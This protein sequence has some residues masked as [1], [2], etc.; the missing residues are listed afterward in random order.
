ME[1]ILFVSAQPDVPYFIWQI[2]L[3]I[4]NFIEKG[5]DP[6][7]IHAVL[8]LV[9]GNTKPSKQSEE[10]KELGVN[11]HYFVD[12][13]VKKHYIPSIKPYLISKWIQSNPEFG[14]LF[15]L[16]DADIIF[17]ELPN[18]EE[19]LNDNTCY[20]SDT[21][22]YIGYD[23][24]MDCC[25]RY[26]QKHP[27]TEKGQLISEMSEVIGVDVDTIKTN[28][29]NSGGGQ[30]LIKNSNCELW[31]KIYKDSIKL[32]DQMLNYQKRFP[33]NPGQIQFWTAEMWALLWNLWMYGFET[34]IT[35]EMSFSWATDDIKKYEQH[36]ILHMAGVTDNLKTTKFYKGDYINIDPILKMRENPN[37]FDYINKDSST[38]K[39]MENM[40]SYIQKYNI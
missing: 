3:Y 10:L 26:E 29:K 36:P 31:D 9:Q 28:Q 32:Y 12:E 2:K 18:F 20:L 27:N 1:N 5:I 13:R 23:Y 40:K 34:K 8:G 33:I 37:H 38:I 35:D 30:Y 19:L 22:G 7:K 4:H 6:N 16:H 25:G 15:F 24:I 14:K 21:I 17:R 11:V 39:Y